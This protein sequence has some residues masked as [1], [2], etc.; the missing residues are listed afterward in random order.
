[1]SLTFFIERR[2]A[3][4]ILNMLLVCVVLIALTAC[5]AVMPVEETTS[6]PAPDAFEHPEALATTEWLA[7]HLNDANLRIVDVRWQDQPN[8]T[9]AHIPGA[10][11]ADLFTDLMVPDAQVPSVAPPPELFSTTM[12]RLGIGPNTTVVAYDVMGG[13]MGAARLWWLL[14]YYGH[15]NVKVLDGGWT[16]WELEERSV[17]AG[18][19]TPEA[20]TFV[21]AAPREEWRATAPLVQL[22]MDN[23]DFM[24]IDALP[25]ENY[26]G[27][28]PHEPP[29]RDGHIPS[30]KNLPAPDNLDPTTMALL[31]RSELEQR[32]AGLGL[33]EDQQAITYCEAGVYSALDFFILYQLG[34]E[35]VRLYE[36]SLMEWGTDPAYPMELGG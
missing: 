25:V 7:D 5:T 28:V 6:A 30:A 35:N 9:A 10:V 2:N 8:Y 17:E 12:Q 29:M 33:H 27:E 16:K 18:E 4:G 21:A 13:A 20:G 3:M 26:T 15:D 31:P 32:W 14:H 19:F 23:A 22:A 36:R 24:V 34:H 11:Y 1:M